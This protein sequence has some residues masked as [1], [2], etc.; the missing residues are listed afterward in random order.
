MGEIPASHLTNLKAQK[1]TYRLPTIHRPLTTAHYFNHPNPMIF[2]HFLP[3][4]HR[5]RV[6]LMAYRWSRDEN[7]G[8]ACFKCRSAIAISAPFFASQVERDL[9][10][11]G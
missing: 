4:A 11:P 2:L 6:S 5:L 10:L 9:L 8:F 7:T 3:P 1:T